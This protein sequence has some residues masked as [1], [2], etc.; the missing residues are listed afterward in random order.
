MK[1]SLIALAALAA[2]SAS[3]VVAAPSAQARPDFGQGMRGGPNPEYMARVLDLTP[4]QQAKV[5]S[6]F[7]EQA[8]RRAQ[9]R[10][11]MRA[12]MQTRMQGI[13]T[14]E[15]YAKMQDLRQ[16]RMESRDGGRGPGKGGQ[17]FAGRGDCPRNGPAPQI[18]Q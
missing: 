10:A 3:L 16:L 8:E 7:E 12:E 18:A 13:L 2:V 15:Q 5:K 17:G 6:L 11:T 4:E 9:M 14:P 1:K